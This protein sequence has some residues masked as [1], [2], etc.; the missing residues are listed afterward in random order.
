MSFSVSAFRPSYVR[1][2][3]WTLGF[4]AIAVVLAQAAFRF[5]PLEAL[6]VLVGLIGC[7]AIMARPFVGV[8][9]LVFLLQVLGLVIHVA[10]SI[11]EFAYVG[12]TALTVFAVIVQAPLRERE[13]RWGG[14][15]P[16]FPLTALFVLWTCLSVAF[17]DYRD[18][19]LEAFLKIVSLVMVLFVIVVMTNTTRRLLMLIVALMMATALSGA[20]STL[21]YLTGGALVGEA[22]RVRLTGAS[23]TDPTTTANVMLVGTLL[24]AFLLCRLPRLRQASLASAILGVCGI[25]LS[26]SRTGMMFLVAG[27]GWL[28]FLLRKSRYAAAGVLFAVVVGVAAIPMLPSTVRERFSQLANPSDDWTLGRRW[29]YHVIGFDLLTQHPILGVGPGAF[30]EH[31]ASFDYRWA[32][33]RRQMARDLHNLYLSTAVEHGLVGFVFFVAMLVWALI[34]L[35]R[36]VKRTRDPTLA[37]LAQGMLLGYGTFLIAVGTLPAISNKMLWVGLG[38]SAAIIN[39]ANRS[40][41]KSD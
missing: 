28:A 14:R 3:Y 36:T 37:I 9:L 22:S 23:S 7:V 10:G 33:G 17:S 31:Y 29:G 32:E 30:Q 21:G 35:R 34:G 25:V 15:S 40:A 27:L 18:A 19:S 16:I 6:V 13:G 8:V 1:E 24:A 12:L 39:V 5:G 11:G 20:V 38:L 2:L 4:C 26:Y 41:A